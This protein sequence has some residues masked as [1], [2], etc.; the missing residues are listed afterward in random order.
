MYVHV[1]GH[2]RM[3]GVLVSHCLISLRQEPG[4]C[5]PACPQPSSGLYLTALGLQAHM[6]ISWVLGSR[7]RVPHLLSK[8]S[9]PLSCPTSPGLFIKHKIFTVF[10]EPPNT[11]FF[12][13]FYIV[14]KFSFSHCRWL[15]NYSET[16]VCDS[17]FGFGVG[18]LHPHLHRLSTSCTLSLFIYYCK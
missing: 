6:A 18:K 9:Y 15:D 8:R 10:S 4:S 2:R 17:W 7:L 14:F 16:W 13:E 11:Q 1:S 12:L 3:P 5:C